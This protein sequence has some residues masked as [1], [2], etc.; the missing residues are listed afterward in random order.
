MPLR[1]VP[2]A[3][4]RPLACAGTLNEK[5]EL[6]FFFTII[7]LLLHSTETGRILWHCLNLR[8]SFR[9]LTA[10]SLHLLIFQE[11]IEQFA[12]IS[13]VYALKSLSHHMISH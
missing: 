3:T 6:K 10:L 11:W 9:E 7:L 4:S 13:Q 2:T 5:N 12:I 1:H 8:R